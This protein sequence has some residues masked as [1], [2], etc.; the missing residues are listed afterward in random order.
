MTHR[1]DCFVVFAEMRTGSNFLEEN[2]NQ[3]PGLKCY[4]EVYNPHFIGY[5]NTTDIHGFTQGMRDADP[6]RLVS[7]LKDNT[8]GLPGF[9]FF[10]DHDPRVLDRLLADPRC[11]KIILTRNPVESYVSWKIAAATGQWK[12]TNMKNQKSAQI[13]FDPA[14]F[15]GHLA[16]LQSF[17]LRLLHGLQTTGQTA[18]YVAYEDIQD[19]EVLNGLARYLGETHQLESASTKL[20]KQNPA[21]LEDKV[22]NFSEMQTALARTDHFDLGRTPNFEPRRGAA[23]PTYVAA[24]GVPL[25]FL[26]LKG[27]PEATIIRWLTDIGQGAEPLGN[28][29]QGTLRQWMRKS[30]GHRRFSVLRHPVARAHT[31]FCDQILSTGPGSYGE[32]RAT[33]RRMHNLPIPEGAVGESYDLAHHRTAFLAFLAFVKANLAGQTNIR[34]DAAWSHQMQ[35]LQGMSNFASSDLILREDRLA[36]GLAF[37]ANDVG[38]RSPELQDIPSGHP[39]ELADFYDGEIEDAVRDVYQRDYVMLGFKRWA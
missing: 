14:E 11:A 28:F 31:V 38:V 34:V 17:Q 20:K 4:G 29:T 22:L 30:P 12:L 23:V 8:Q 27:G 24:A 15:K 9:R 13:R 5:P 3:F 7:V 37:L 32:I 18:F 35:V 21:G 19:V 1:F 6:L 26:T 25:L 33:L 2:I 16:Q 39:F 10:H 36:E